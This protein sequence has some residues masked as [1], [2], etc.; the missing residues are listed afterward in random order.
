MRTGIVGIGASLGGLEAMEVVFSFLRPGFPCPIVL[1]Q[2]RMPHAEGLLVELVQGYCPL[3]VSEPDDKDPILPGHVYIAPPNYHLLVDDG[4][5]SLS[6]EAPVSFARPSMDVFFESVADA[7]RS[8]SLAIF[9][10]GSNRDGAAG[11]RAVK[12]A[13]GTVLV[14]DPKTAESPVCPLAVL[15]STLVDQVLDL[16]GLARVLATVG[17]DG[18]AVAS[19]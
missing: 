18:A 14:Q 15:E 13:G 17:V 10:T 11:A 5:F 6:L 3:P 16:R 9:L 19:H 7:Y 2:H 4:Y 1:V 12:R 8:R